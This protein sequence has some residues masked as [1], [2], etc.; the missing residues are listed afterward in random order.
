[1]TLKELLISNPDRHLTYVEYLTTEE[2][3]SKRNEMK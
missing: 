2:W 3:D 1:M